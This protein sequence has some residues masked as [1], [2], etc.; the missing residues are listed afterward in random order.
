MLLGSL[1]IFI[2]FTIYWAKRFKPKYTFTFIIG[3]PGSGKT[4]LMTKLAFKYIKKGWTVYAN[5]EIPGTYTIPDSDITKVALQ[6]DSVLLIDEIAL[7]WSNRNFKTFTDEARSWWKL[8][9]H[10]K[11]KIFAFSQSLDADKS[12]RLLATKLY[13]LVNYFGIYSVAKEVKRKFPVISKDAQGESQITDEYKVS[14]FFTAPFG[15]RMYT[16]I[17]RWAKYFDSFDAPPLP[18]KEFRYIPIPDIKNTLKKGKRKHGKLLYFNKIS[19]KNY[20]QKK[21]I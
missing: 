5:V 8:Y 12:I 11:L 2:V 19:S 6:P 7:I 4:T 20:E 15:G 3:K 21:H 9:R 18:E 10:R 14:P 13:C 1:V 17:P 16:F